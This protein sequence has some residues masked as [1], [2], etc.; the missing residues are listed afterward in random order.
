M[1]LA[2]LIDCSLLGLVFAIVSFS[3]DFLT[4]IVELVIFLAYMIGL[5]FAFGATAGFH[6]LG[7]K[8]VSIN[9]AKP[10]YQTDR[11]QLICLDRVLFYFWTELASGI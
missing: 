11:L 10:H 7:M 5:K 4:A 8:I 6:L 9:G 3:S 1:A 2:N